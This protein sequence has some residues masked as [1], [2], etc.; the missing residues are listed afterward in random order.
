[1]ERADWAHLKEEDDSVRGEDEV[2][3]DKGEDKV[4]GDGRFSGPTGRVSPARGGLKTRE[5]IRF[6]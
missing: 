4:V 5:I 1:M 6:I 3:G 2:A